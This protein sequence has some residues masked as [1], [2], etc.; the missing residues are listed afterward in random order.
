V[1][2]GCGDGL[3][4]AIY[5]DP[6]TWFGFLR[7]LVIARVDPDEPGRA[8]EIAWYA[9][10]PGVLDLDDL[11]LRFHEAVRHSSVASAR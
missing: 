9:P 10:P 2:A 5:D 1:L 8:L 4:F 6:A 3:A 11:R 7:V